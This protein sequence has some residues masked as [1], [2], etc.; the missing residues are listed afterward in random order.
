M[1]GEKKRIEFMGYEWEEIGGKWLVKIDDLFYD[2]DWNDS[3][4]LISKLCKQQS[5]I[6]KLR[7]ENASLKQ[8]IRDIKYNNCD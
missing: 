1:M 4:S 7:E 2:I 3:E 5:I 6:N 8:R